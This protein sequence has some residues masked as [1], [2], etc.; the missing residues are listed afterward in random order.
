MIHVVLI[1]NVLN[2]FTAIGPFPSYV[3]ASK[4]ARVENTAA[5]PDFSGPIAVCTRVKEIADSDLRGTW[6]L[7]EGSIAGGFRLEG[8]LTRENAE[9]L[10]ARH[11]CDR[12]EIVRPD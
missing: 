10:A 2:G 3:E 8:P 4:R 1:G 11:E 6:A 5:E 7:V 9:R 12:I